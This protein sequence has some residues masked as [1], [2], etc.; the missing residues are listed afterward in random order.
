MKTMFRMKNIKTSLLTGALSVVA[1]T[2]CV[3]ENLDLGNTE[4]GVL[5]LSVDIV[6]PQSRS[7]TEVTSYPVVIYDADGNVNFSYNS[8]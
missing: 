7:L 6:Q 8:V 4:T 1:L 5:E 3:S 2:S